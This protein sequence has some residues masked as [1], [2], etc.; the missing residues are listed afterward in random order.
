MIKGTWIRTLETRKEENERER[1]EKSKDGGKKTDGRGRRQIRMR[2]GRTG[3]I[4]RRKRRRQPK[5][6]NIE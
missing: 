6:K 4:R 1:G 3:K 2:I 5:Q